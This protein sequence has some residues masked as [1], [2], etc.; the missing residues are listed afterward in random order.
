MQTTLEEPVDRLFLPSSSPVDRGQRRRAFAL[1]LLLVGALAATAPYATIALTGTGILLPAY[2]TAVLVTDLMTA[3]L[4]VG[5]FTVERS[6]AVLLLA[7]GYLFA[8]LTVVPWALTFPGAFAPDGLLGGGLQSTA[9]IAAVRR[10]GFP[11]C[12]LGY[13]LMARP[14]S[15][16]GTWRGPVPSAVAASIAAVFLLAVAVSWLALAE[17]GLLPALMTSRSQASALWD[18]VPGAAV[19]L[20]L[21]GLI[22]LWRRG[23][24]V[25]DLWLMVVLCSLLI[26]ILLLAGLSGG[27]FSLGWWAG[28][29]YGLIAASVV[30]LVLL[31]ETTILQGRLARSIA[32]ERR[33]REAR[34]ST[35]EAL[36]A[37]IA[38]EVNQPLSSMVTNADAAVRWLDR[39]PPD[40]AEVRAALSRIAEDGHR[41]GRIVEST[42]ATL[43]RGRRERQPL[44]VNALLGHVAARWR[45]DLEL[46]RVSLRL[47]LAET[48]PPVAGDPVQL[49]QVLCNL[50]GNALEALR[51]V[52]DRV[53]S[54]EI[55]S[56]P[57][58][59]RAV[60]IS[61]S[62]NGPG[63]GPADGE[64][65]FEPFFT[66]KP[67]GL[68]M[69][70]MFC[71]SV[72]EAH[73]GRL[74]AE[75]GAPGARFRFTLPAESGPVAEAGR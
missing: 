73:G 54:V 17:Q 39:S 60:L 21:A 9:A 71:R 30:L 14:G 51:G 50:V 19:L 12:I 28:R 29:L 18:L 25:L 58:G 34:L 41:A 31:S 74:W 69:G 59:E 65:I 33:G 44:E 61:V 26:E 72:I 38:H 68:G 67:D 36:S 75:P 4:L 23:R 63:F 42:R 52:D 46:D 53:R 13:A 45:D 48:L 37:S 55:A 1:L 3:I 10:L 2:A 22:L 47:R 40:L 64:R 32:A 27:R 70:L 57:E 11:L 62:D 15:A 24:C 7:S 56:A 43:R 66:T 35:L 6:P 49:E 5:V 20:C 8:G 16:R